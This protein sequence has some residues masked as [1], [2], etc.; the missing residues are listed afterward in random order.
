VATLPYIY[1]YIYTHTHIHIYIYTHTHTHTHTQT[2]TCTYMY[3]IITA[4]TVA[5]N[6]A[7]V[8]VREFN[9]FYIYI[10]SCN[11]CNLA[12]WDEMYCI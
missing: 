10:C 9:E 1:I 7:T 2:D 5:V 12:I 4:E 8:Q 11:S 6:K 3:D